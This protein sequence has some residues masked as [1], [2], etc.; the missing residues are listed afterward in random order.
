MDRGSRGQLS[1]RQV[2]CNVQL[3]NGGRGEEASS[4]ELSRQRLCQVAIE[5]PLCLV[6]AGSSAMPR[7]LPLPCAVRPLL[8]CPSTCQQRR[9][10]G[11]ATKQPTRQPPT[12]RVRRLHGHQRPSPPLDAMWLP[13]GFGQRGS[14]ASRQTKVRP[15]EMPLSLCCRF[16][17][18][19]TNVCPRCIATRRQAQGGRQP[20]RDC[21]VRMADAGMSRRAPGAAAKRTDGHT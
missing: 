14:E 7:L 5:L 18:P 16:T 3:P 10:G 12:R 13:L 4:C 11:R 15:V 1:A 8:V 17:H 21:S 9:R 19:V 2:G 6:G 20:C